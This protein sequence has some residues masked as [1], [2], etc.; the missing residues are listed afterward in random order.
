[1]RVTPF[2]FCFVVIFSSVCIAQDNGSEADSLAYEKFLMMVNADREQSYLTFGNGIGNLEPLLLEAKLSPSYFFSKNRNRWA[3]MINPQVQVRMLNERSLPIRNPSYR[4]YATVYK[5]LEFWKRSFLRTAFYKNALLYASWVHH[6]NGQ[7][8]PFYVNDTT[9][10]VNFENG[11][12]SS[13]FLQLGVSTYR[14]DELG[15]HYYSIREVKVLLEYYPSSWYSEGLKDRYGS[16]RIF[17][18]VGLVGPRKKIKQEKIMRW[19]QR[20]SLEI[21][22]GWIFGKMQG[23][24]PLEASSRLV[25]D[26]WYKYYPVWFDEIAFFIRFYRGQDYYNIHFAKPPITNLSIGITSN[27]MNY[28]QAVRLFK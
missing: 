13:N 11:D 3:V 15:R 19:M 28:K 14:V 24:A 10:E 2:L 25:I 27:I 17:G 22:T 7:D 12:F 26:L 1:M 16:Y 4:V 18:S 6:S 23:A 20:S 9:R 5:E 21:K 8:G